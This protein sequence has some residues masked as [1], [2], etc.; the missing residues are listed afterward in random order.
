MISHIHL[1][2]FKCFRTVDIRPKQITAF[3]GANGTGK[4]SVLQAFGLLKQS[5]AP[6]CSQQLGLP[7]IKGP[8][9]IHQGPLVFQGPLVMAKQAKDLLHG[10]TEDLQPSS[11]VPMLDFEGSHNWLSGKDEKQLFSCRVTFFANSSD[12][13]NVRTQ[14]E[15]ELKTEGPT[16][17]YIRLVPATRELTRPIY[18]LGLAIDSD[19]SLSEAC[20]E[21]EEQ[22]A[23]NLAYSYHIVKRI[24]ALINRIVGI[25]L[26][27]NTV[28]PLSVEIKALTADR[29]IE[30]VCEGLGAN[31]L[32]LTLMPL[33][34]GV[35]DSTVM[36]EEPKFTCTPRPRLNWP[37][38]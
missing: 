6:Y 2:S 21:Y 18:R 9:V 36:I 35:S 37:R 12:S 27:A 3:V 29:E 22:S 28:P 5:S 15:H 14:Y 17:K 10:R 16:W 11:V 32:A 8:L 24:S 25:R 23:T 19:G 13:L 33:F 4:S 31:S 1:Q 30:L 38:C 7:N 20:T 34:F 26:R